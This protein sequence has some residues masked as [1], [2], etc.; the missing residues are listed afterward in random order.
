MRSKNMSQKNEV[1]HS[2]NCQITTQTKVKP[3]S[4]MP[5]RK[6][7]EEAKKTLYLGRM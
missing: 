4:A 5:S 7:K 2:P 3:A 1:R 6:N